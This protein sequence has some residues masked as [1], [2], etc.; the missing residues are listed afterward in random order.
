MAERDEN[1]PHGLKLAIKDYPFANDGLMLWD[2]LLE[3]MTE[4]VHHYYPDEKAIKNDKELKAW[5]KEIMEKGHPDKKKE[6]GWP[7]LKTPKDL[8]QIV[9]TI[10]WVGCGHHSAVNFIQYA[11]AG[12]FPSRPSIARTNMPTEDLDQIPEEFINNPESVLLEAFPS[13]AQAST[14][15]Q[16]M[17]ILSAHSP[18]EEYIGSKIEAAWEE[19]PIIAKAFQKFKGRLDNL[20]K[21]IDEK[22]EDTNFKNRRGAGLVPYEV[23]KPTS[24]FGVT[25]KGVPYSVST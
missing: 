14:V 7:A 4:Y 15:A 19:N 21:S 8:I 20:D 22:N 16:T 5:W 18:D 12:Y 6:A 10:A 23:L 9:S 2:A 11:H 1:A 25:G 13:V 3:W 17:L 24:S